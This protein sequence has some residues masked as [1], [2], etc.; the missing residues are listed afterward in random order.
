MNTLNF[1]TG[2]VTYQLIGQCEVLFNPTDAAFVEKLFSAFD[3]LDR[4]QEE[5]KEKMKASEDIRDTFKIARKMD[6]EMRGIIDAVFNCPVC[7]AV[8]HE[9]N[10]YALADGLPVWSNLL[11]S[12]IDEIDD[13]MTQEQKKT[14]PRLAKYLD[15]YQKK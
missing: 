1:S 9:M 11:L 12:V 13:A 6:A 3:S 15:K 4:M 14:N 7:D 10:V 5:N 2:I 8:F